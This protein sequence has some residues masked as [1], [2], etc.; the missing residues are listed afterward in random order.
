MAHSR[1]RSL[2]VPVAAAIVAGAGLG[3][4]IARTAEPTVTVLLEDDVTVLGQPIVY[5]AAGPP[6]VTAMIVALEP[7]VATGWHRHDA[8][9]FARMLEG[10]LTVDYGPH[11]KRRYVAGDSLLEAVEV[12]HNGANTGDVEARVLVVYMGAEGVA[13][14]APAPAPD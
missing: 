9:L 4:A 14:S 7:G 1:A 5:P 11:G 2:V 8:P 12:A 3:F 10:E 13:N 6:K